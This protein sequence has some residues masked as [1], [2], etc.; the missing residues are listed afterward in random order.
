MQ[1]LKQLWALPK[2]IWLISVAI[3]INRMGTM[4]MVFLSLYITKNLGYPL[5][6]A[7]YVMAIYGLTALVMSPYAGKLSDKFGSALMVEITLGLSGLMLLLYP[8]VTS[9]HWIYLLTVVL[10]AT[11]ES[12][13]PACM[14]LLG[15]LTPPGQRALSQALYRLAINL[16]MSIGPA[17]GGFLALISYKWIF[18][19]D[20]M[21][22]LVSL[23][24]LLFTSFHKEAHAVHHAKKN[25]VH[26]ITGAALKNKAFVY[27]LLAM[28]PAMLVMFQ[29]G[30]TFPLYVV[31]ELHFSESSY[32]LL[33]VVNTVLVVLLEIPLVVRLQKIKIRTLIVLGALLYGLGFGSLMLSHQMWSLSLSVTV[34]TFGEI[35]FSCSSMAYITLLAPENKRGEYMGYYAMA[36]AFAFSVA[37]FVG[38]WVMQVMGSQYL[39]G[40]SL[41]AGLISVVLL[42]KV[43][44]HEPVL[45]AA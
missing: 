5:M 8:F 4:A 37:P 33:C 22:C 7:G 28:L 20:G 23:A 18:W 14:T 3:L 9:L 31:Q 34:W 12:F 24:F 29:F 41:L 45:Q 39:W 6:T 15:D 35:L 10:A 32:G 36:F 25:V 40:F 27:Y 42:Q 30:T 1:T 13:R 11:S 38:T 17:I 21:T 26:A 43:I 2:S 16:G 19:I 44:S